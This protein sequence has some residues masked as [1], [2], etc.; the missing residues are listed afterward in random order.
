MRAFTSFILQLTWL[1]GRLLTP[2]Y[3]EDGIQ[4]V[5]HQANR[6][7]QYPSNLPF[8][9][10]LL[11][12]ELGAQLSAKDQPS[13]AAGASAGILLVPVSTGL[14]DVGVHNRKISN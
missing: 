14:I 3:G 2:C 8:L 1:Y 10:C 4:P 9:Q 13:D 12:K 7:S 6:D 11:L 5:L